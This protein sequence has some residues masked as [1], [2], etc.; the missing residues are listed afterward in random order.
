MKYIPDTADYKSCK[1]KYLKDMF[2]TDKWELQ[3]KVRAKP[4]LELLSNLR[5]LKMSYFN[6]N[7][8]SLWTKQERMS[9]L[10]CVFIWAPLSWAKHDPKVHHLFTNIA[11][12]QSKHTSK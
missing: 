11:Q 9:N 6:L 8:T 4:I 5:D 10:L 7:T 2:I 1:Y 12:H 3:K